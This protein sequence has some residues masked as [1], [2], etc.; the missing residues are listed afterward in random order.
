MA[1]ARTCVRG[2]GCVPP[3]PLT[4]VSMNSIS[5]RDLCGCQAI[6]IPA[7]LVTSCP[8]ILAWM[9]FLP[10]AVPMKVVL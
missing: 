1:A 2:P 5:V 7:T 9:V 4:P 10:A 3:R 8:L 6:V